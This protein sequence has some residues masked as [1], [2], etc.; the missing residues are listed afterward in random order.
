MQWP[1]KE[2]RCP[3]LGAHVLGVAGRVAV[4]TL[5]EVSRLYCLILQAHQGN[6]Q[7]PCCHAIRI[8]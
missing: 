3:H 6:Y 8:T 1:V 5:Q 4:T 2:W 7:K